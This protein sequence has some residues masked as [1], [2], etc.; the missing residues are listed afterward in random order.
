[1]ITA[2][3]LALFVQIAVAE[4]Q[5]SARTAEQICEVKKMANLTVPI[6]V[7]ID[8][9]EIKEYLTSNDVV[10]VKHGEWKHNKNNDVIKCSECGFGI[11]DSTF[12]WEIRNC[13]GTIED[14]PFNF[15]PNCGADMRGETE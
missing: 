2:L 15:C 11:M 3:I 5:N 10:E 14:N 13:C 8:M 12:V 4:R 7:K 1:M 6:I 9:D